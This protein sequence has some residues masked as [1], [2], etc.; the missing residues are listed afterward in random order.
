MSD[1]VR[2][3][4]STRRWATWDNPALWYVLAL[5]LVLGCWQLFITVTSTADYLVPRPA[6]VFDALGDYRVVILKAAWVTTRTILIAF[7][8]STVVGIAVAIPI[9]FVR[10]VR[11]ISS[12]LLAISQAVPRI[13]LAPLF[14]VWFGFGSKT[15]VIIAVSVALFPIIVNTMLGLLSITPDVVN[16]GR[17]MGGGRLRIFR[18]LRWPLALPS[19]FAGLKVAVTLAV[20][21]AVVGEFIVGSDGLGYLTISAS[22]NQNS[23]LL[24]ACVIALSIIGVAFFAVIEGLEKLVL[25]H[26]PGSR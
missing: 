23:S 1:D 19:I 6:K 10:P 24:F 7:L 16:L 13:A 8:I 2:A 14:I 11:L 9:A 26:H 17:S 5:A 25:R 4:R 18:Y 3:V 21:G 20:V 12:P 15:N 22:A